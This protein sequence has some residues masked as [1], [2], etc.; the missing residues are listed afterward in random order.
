MVAWM[1]YL[2]L[3]HKAYSNEQGR[4]T[5]S[6]N[7]KRHRS[8]QSEYERYIRQRRIPRRSLLLVEDSPW[9][10]VFRSGDPQAMIT[11]TGFD[12]PSFQYLCALFAPYYNDFSLFLDVENG[13]ILKKR[14]NR[15]RPR[16]MTA[17]DC[18]G[19]V[20]GWSCT[21]GSLMVLQLIFGMS[22]TPDAK[23]LRYARRILVSVLRTNEMAK[24]S[25]PSNAQLED[26]RSMIEARHPALKDVWGT[27]D[28]LKVTIKAAGNFL[29]QSRFYNGWKCDHFVTSVLCFVPDGTIP[30]AAF[31]FPGCSHDSTVAEWGDLYGK[32]ESV[33]NSTGLQFVVDS[34]F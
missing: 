1:W 18:L 12:L 19:L 5:P 26:Y 21:R 10:R 4:R 28:R 30:A 32:L 17:E 2:L 25:M 22:M 27:M 23:Y 34:A 15:G 20:L 14:T 33:Y 7:R 8:C 13:Y 3:L 6:R 16:L 29:T 31:N 11:L 24:I 9:R